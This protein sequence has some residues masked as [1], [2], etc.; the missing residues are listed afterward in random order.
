MTTFQEEQEV[1][2]DSIEALLSNLTNCSG[3]QSEQHSVLIHGMGHHPRS[4]YRQLANNP[5]VEVLWSG[6][7]GPWWLYFLSFIPG[8][9]GLLELKTRSKVRDI[10]SLV[11]ELSMCALYFFPTA[12]HSQIV[13][14]IR[15]YKY[16]FSVRDALKDEKDYFILE[17]DFDY[18]SD[19]KDS[20][21]IFKG[22]SCG[23]NLSDE[24][25]QVL[26]GV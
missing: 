24:L 21:V 9:A 12:L 15:R 4:F 18:V 11:G 6:W 3:L 14:G 25:K 5:D 16:N 22:L 13:D 8:Q 19:K 2:R 26:Q 10:F 7:C 20:D 23:S 17:V 1:S